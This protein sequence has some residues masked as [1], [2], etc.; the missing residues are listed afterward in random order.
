MIDHILTQDAKIIVTTTDKYGD[1]NKSSETSIKCKFRNS[2][3]LNRN[4][5]AELV[6]ASADAVAYF[7]SDAAVAEGTILYIDSMYWRVSKLI[8]ARRMSNPSLVFL[9]AYL[10][11]HDLA[12][13]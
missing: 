13:V 5:N 12:G 4:Q 8:K 1:Q 9:K 7:S 11:K 6:T 2:V 10:N 3:E